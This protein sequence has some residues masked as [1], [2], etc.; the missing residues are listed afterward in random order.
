MQRGSYTSIRLSVVHTEPKPQVSSSV[1]FGTFH[2]QLLTADRSCTE[3]S[4]CWMSL[5]SCDKELLH[6]AK[7]SINS[8]SQK[9]LVCRYLVQMTT[10]VFVIAK[11]TVFEVQFLR[12][13][14]KR[15]KYGE[16]SPKTEYLTS[17][18]RFFEMSSC[19]MEYCI[20]LSRLTAATNTVLLWVVKEATPVRKGSFLFFSTGEPQLINQDNKQE[21]E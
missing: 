20:L 11:R 15:Q 16:G 2:I 12:A 4:H 18:F 7:A 5:R 13:P 1:G 6:D 8:K 21:R 14:T 19:V 10:E 3:L 17:I 9:L